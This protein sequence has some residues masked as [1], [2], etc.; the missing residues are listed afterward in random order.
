[1][2]PF[3]QPDIIIYSN[4]LIHSYLHWTGK[5]LAQ[6]AE[7]L[8]HAPFPVISHGTQPDPIFCYA[9]LTAQKLWKMDWATFTALPSR[10]S[11]EPDAQENR[12]ALLAAAASQGYV[13]NY[14]G[15][16]ITAEGKRFRIGQ[17]MLW[18]VVKTGGEKIGQAAS[19]S[20][21][22]FI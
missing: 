2:L 7:A 3:E 15:I 10:L 21:W 19:F 5:L 6:D 9:N 20:Q 12:Q 14:S 1:M 13:D 16:R 8:Y 4:H 11:A 18:N 22:E 17:C